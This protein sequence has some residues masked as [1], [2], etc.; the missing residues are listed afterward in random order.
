MMTPAII[1]TIQAELSAALPH[2]GMSERATL[3]FL[4]RSENTAFLAED[5]LAG[6]RLVLRVQ[7]IG[8]HSP[9]E[10]VSEEKIAY[11]ARESGPSSRIPS[12]LLIAWTVF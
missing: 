4:S 6:Q 5:P 9:A 7:R 3:A 2:W 11:T 12:R 10:I 1:E 8:Y